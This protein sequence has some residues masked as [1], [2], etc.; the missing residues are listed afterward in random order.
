FNGKTELNTVTSE[1]GNFTNASA[2][3]SANSI[4]NFIER[5]VTHDADFSF[6][7]DL[8]NEWADF[9]KIQVS[10]PG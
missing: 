5:G 10:I 4:F 8:G 6:L 2:A 3:F 9:I 1:K 7:D